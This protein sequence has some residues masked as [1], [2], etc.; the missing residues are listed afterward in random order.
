MDIHKL[1]GK[2]PFRPKRGYVLPRH[3]FTGPWNPLPKQ[4]D[5][6][7]NPV[8]GQEPFN[9]VDEVSRR[10]DI[11]YRDNNNKAGKRKCD[12]TML[13]DLDSVQ[14]KNRREKVDKH[15]VKAVIK[16]KNKLGW[17]LN[18]KKT[19]TT[20]T[21]TT[22]KKK[23]MIRWSDEL[24]DELHK[25]IR[26]KFLKR[27]VFA[28]NVDDIWTADLVD[29][30]SFSRDNK[31]IKYLLTVIDVFSKYGWIIPLKTKT[32]SAV[33][34]AF[35]TL[36]ANNKPPAKLWTD[37][38]TE[39]YNVNVKKVLNEHNVSLYSTENEEKSSVVER[40]NR[41]MKTNMWKY[42][43][44]NNT[45]TYLD[46]LQK[47][48]DKYNTTYHHSIKCTPSQA[49]KPE[50]YAHVFEALFGKV[51][52][53]K[54]KDPK[55]A[56]GDRVRISKKKKQFEKGFTPN[57]TEEVFVI[58]QVK[59]TKPPTYA[60][61]DLRG[62]PVK[63]SFYE[64]ELQLSKQEVYRVEKVIRKR[65]KNGVDEAYVKW[66]GYGKEFDS[67]IPASDLQKT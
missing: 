31:G 42:F 29:M 11:C 2:L 39:F 21:T 8:P 48:V 9:E 65:K 66:K 49:R 27:T 3:R 15:L 57:W 30:Q 61:K 47:L 38:G 59:D 51:N 64:E 37:K 50:K 13:T 33:A 36:F 14:P 44:A 24:A 52:R 53:E 43:T 17:G 19:T 18:G 32:G 12:E 16:T 25:Q 35:R 10:H 23:E 41:T 5:S 45:H 22:K 56:V 20:T 63:G 54:K 4:L 7:D 46:V 6:N 58:D 40:W 67:W 26:R 55:F 34:D 1:I 60:L 62:E 28:K